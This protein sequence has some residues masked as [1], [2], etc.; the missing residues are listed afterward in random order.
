MARPRAIV[1]VSVERNFIRMMLYGQPS[2]GKS[3][4][5]GTSPKCLILAS[6]GEE[7]LSAA[8]FGSQADMWV[9]PDYSELEDAVEYVRH[10]G[11]NDYE[12]V[13]L[14]NATLFQEQGLDDTME[15]LFAAKPNTTQ[16]RW[17]P[18][19]PQYLINQNRMSRIIR[20]LK[21]L[22]IHFGMTAHEMTIAW[23]DGS[24]N[25]MPMLLGKQGE[26]SQKICGYTNIIGHVTARTLKGGVFEQKIRFQRTTTIYAKDRYHALGSSMVNPNIPDMLEKIREVL[27]TVGQRVKPRPAKKA[28]KATPVKKA[29][30]K[31]VAKKATAT[32][33]KAR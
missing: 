5:A 25:K 3:V 17:V 21:G 32:T 8:R 15:D 2:T 16:S 7:P 6:D 20:M 19:R 29:A 9:V 23:A 13:W 27:P 10:D 24:E 11:I 28:V 31:T 4:V 30:T 33:R 1:P 18:D 26:Y 12:W 22:P 14:D